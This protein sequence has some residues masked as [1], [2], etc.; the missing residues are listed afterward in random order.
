[1]SE[2]SERAR[3]PVAVD[4]VALTIRDDAL[5]VV[6]VNRRKA[7]RRLALPGG[8]VFARESLEKAADRKFAGE[9]G[10]DPLPLRQI[11]V[12][13]KPDRDPRERVITV[14]YLGIGHDLP[15]PPRGTAA[16]PARWIP[17]SGVLDDSVPLAF[18]HRDVLR[19]A[20]AHLRAAVEDSTA[21]MDFCAESFTIGELRRVY[22]LVWDV[23]LDARNFYRKIRNVPGF[24]EP[25]GTFRQ[26][27]TGRPAQEFRRGGAVR[28]ETPVLR[29]AS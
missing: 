16:G 19:D 8:F 5:R 17:A 11:R 4:I 14:S 21:A 2:D 26:T 1:M 6:V 9:T 13:S 27:S 10:L 15:D 29:P 22:E 24:I 7:P 12:Y 23:T 18:D 28:L 25:T 3:F 20:I